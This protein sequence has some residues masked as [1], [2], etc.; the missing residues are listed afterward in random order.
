MVRIDRRWMRDHLPSRQN[1]P[2]TDPAAETFGPAGR[3]ENPLKSPD[4]KRGNL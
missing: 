3:V 4:K 1:F 2:I